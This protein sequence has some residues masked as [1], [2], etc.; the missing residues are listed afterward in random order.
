VKED[1]CVLAWNKAAR[2]LLGYSAREVVGRKCH[3]VIGAVFPNGEPLCTPS[4]EGGRCFERGRPFSVK[5]CLALHRDGRRVALELLSNMVVP[6]TA[7]GACGGA[8]ASAAIVFLRPKQDMI[9]RARPLDQ[10]PRIYT[11]GHFGLVLNGRQVAVEG[12]ARKQSLILLK[13]LVAHRGTTIHR[14]R[15]MD[16]LWP[17][18]GQDRARQRLK[19]T[20][21]FLRQ[22][23][24]AAGM[25]GDFIESCGDG[26]LLRGEA[27][28]VDADAFERLATVG[29]E[30]ARGQKWHEALRCY[31]DALVIYRGDYLEE[32]TYADWCAEERGRLREIYFEMLERTAH[33][34]I[35]LGRHAEAAQM[36]HTAL[37]REPCRESFHHTLMTCLAELG[38]PDQA[39]VQ[40]RRCRQI[41]ARE[42]DVEPLPETYRLYRRILEERSIGP[43]LAPKRA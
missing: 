41:L 17:E 35:T 25:E 32:D 23:V 28:W 15:L 24:R 19:V 20:V 13:Y 18:V 8:G 14:E 27:V 6:R 42:L 40:F 22:Q 26:Y 10:P 31:E 36:C 16:C 38:R 7:N 12:W 34:Y 2:E 30:L 9:P 5:S 39:L 43:K 29:I 11:L 3:E 1:R 37:V 33:I 4:C 21:Y